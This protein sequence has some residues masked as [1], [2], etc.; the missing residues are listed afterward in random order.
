VAAQSK[1]GSAAAR[2]LELWVRIP[3]VA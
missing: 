2:D 3:P 1:A